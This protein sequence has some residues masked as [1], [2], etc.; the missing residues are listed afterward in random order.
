MSDAEKRVLGSVLVR[1]D[2]FHDCDLYPSEFQNREFGKVWQTISLMLQRGEA[3]DPVTVAE[4]GYSIADLGELAMASG[5]A[6]ENAP[7]YAKVMRRQ[8]QK[9]QANALLRDAVERIQDPAADVQAV[10]AD[11]QMSLEQVAAIGGQAL[12]TGSDAVKDLE[13]YVDESKALTKRFGIPGIPTGH[14]ALQQVLS[15]WRRKGFYVLAARPGEGKS[16]AAFWSA[17][18]AAE[19]GVK[20]GYFTVEMS[21]DE[22][23]SRYIACESGEFLGSIL[24]GQ[25]QDGQRYAQAVERFMNLPVMVDDTSRELNAVVSRMGAMKRAGC[26]V[27]FFDHMGLIRAEGHE[28]R[29]R[30]LGHITQELR[31]AAKRLDVAVVGLYQLNRANQID[32]RPPSLH[33]L[34]GSGEIEENAT[35]VLFLHNVT[36]VPEGAKPPATRTMQWIVPKNRNGRRGIA[37]CTSEFDPR[38]Q[39]WR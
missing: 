33:D 25:V 9:R 38:Y 6:P 14:T 13:A 28:S 10:I 22:L 2:V 11:T 37:P 16:S 21:A 31:Q 26:E 5:F 29:V 27:I 17:C 19:H 30:E 1:P 3:V 35:H 39:S 36:A 12:M 34:R 32:K 24:R 15:G 23:A 20:V 8:S 4:Y 7:E 18:T